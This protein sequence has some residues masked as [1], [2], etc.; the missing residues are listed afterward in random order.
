MH[1]V[2]ES[3]EE[4]IEE[5]KVIKDAINQGMGSFTP[6]M[7]FEN[8]VK[9]YRNAE[10]IYGK[11]IIRYL[12]GYDA[13]YV[14]RNVKIPEFQKEIKKNI[15]EAIKKLK[16][17]DL[18]D[19]Q[20]AI[21][22]KGFYLAS[23]IL[24]TEELDNIV[25]KG[26][27]G[28]YEHKKTS[29]YGLPKDTKIFKKG[30]RYHDIA[31][32]KSVKVAIRRGH[33]KLEIDDL[34]AHERHS[35]GKTVIIYAMDASGS[36]KGKKLEASKK[37]GIAL[38]FKAINK[39]DKIGMIVFKNKVVSLVEPTQDFG[40]LL[41]EITPIKAS[42]ETDFAS[43]ISKAIELFP[44]ER[45][46]KHLIILSDALA[47]YGA[48]P[49]NET[50]SAISLAKE[51]GITVSLIGINLDTKGEELSRKIVEISEGRFWR[52]S[53]LDELDKIVLED[54]NEIRE[55]GTSS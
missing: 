42:G 41:K 52:V 21:T 8:L 28:E 38:A 35:K 29:H 12:T 33:S 34:R 43:T 3:D 44:S 36:M 25:P 48:D 24:Y 10:N 50:L 26:I 22:D 47:T 14:K 11:S 15:G 17:K 53:N 45:I 51:N 20:F 9:D 5:G 32:K 46:T 27:L 23:L 6:D 19:K 18:I 30:D 49:E 1:S 55:F 54:Y 37:A 31:V 40:L 13:D 4:T 39:K 7:M 16:E 2:L